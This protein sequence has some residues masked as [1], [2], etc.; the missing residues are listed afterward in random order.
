MENITFNKL[1]IIIFLSLSVAIAY[2]SH[3]KITNFLAACV[4]SGIITSVIYTMFILVIVGYLDS[5]FFV[6]LGA[7]SVLGFIIAAVT[8]LPIARMKNKKRK[9]D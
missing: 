2:Y 4:F 7:G 5:Y 9:E 3:K 8:G 6:S 1:P